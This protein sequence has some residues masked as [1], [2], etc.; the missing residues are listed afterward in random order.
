MKIRRLLLTCLLFAANAANAQVNV[1]NVLHSAQSLVQ[2]A[3]AP[4]KDSSVS[5]KVAAT[6]ITG[7]QPLSGPPY[8][9]FEVSARGRQYANVR[10]D[11]YFRCGSSQPQLLASSLSVR[12]I[13]LGDVCALS[14][15]TR[16]TRYGSNDFHGQLR[17]FLIQGSASALQNASTAQ[18]SMGGQISMFDASRQQWI[19]NLFTSRSQPAGLARAVIVSVQGTVCAA[20]LTNSLQSGNSFRAALEQKY[21]KPSAEFDLRA[22]MAK[23]AQASK[24]ASG[25]Y[26]DQSLAFGDGIVRDDLAYRNWASTLPAGTVTELD[27]RTHD[28]VKLAVVR[29]PDSCGSNPTFDMTLT[30]DN[31]APKESQFLVRDWAEPLGA[32]GKA[33][34]N[35][36]SASAPTPKF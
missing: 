21:G 27:W 20:D 24:H 2:Q 6:P 25:Q 30:L 13:T 4:G 31:D 22:S 3:A 7:I 17:G 11:D 36:R 19:I 12:G 10:Y 1:F 35:A 34:T 16:S 14:D 26:G 8:G 5:G 18:N 29:S 23:H 15:E 32:F 9:E 28:G 33:Q